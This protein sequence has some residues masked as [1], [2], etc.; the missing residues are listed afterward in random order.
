MNYTFGSIKGL[1]GDG[2]GDLLRHLCGRRRDE[3]AERVE[4]GAHG[5]AGADRRP[6]LQTQSATSCRRFRETRA[7]AT[8]QQ[9]HLK[10]EQ[11]AHESADEI[12]VA[13]PAASART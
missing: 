12:E 8:E 2:E 5:S 4:A 10:I 1:A 11:L 7:M 6:T 9:E 13:S 3:A